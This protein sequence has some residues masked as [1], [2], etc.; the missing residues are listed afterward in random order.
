[1]CKLP[2]DSS[3]CR[4]G[5]W[6]LGTGAIRYGHLPK[7]AA[8]NLLHEKIHAEAA[9][10]IVLVTRGERKNRARAVGPVVDMRD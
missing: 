6:Y 5:L 1:M 7:F 4:F 9:K 2:L 8:L 3:R 10:L